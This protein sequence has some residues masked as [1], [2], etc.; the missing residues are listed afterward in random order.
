MGFFDI[1]TV[2]LIR[3]GAAFEELRLLSPYSK[4][5]LSR[6]ETDPGFCGL[7]DRP[8]HSN[9]TLL[10]TPTVL[11]VADDIGKQKSLSANIL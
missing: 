11:Q 9:R 2:L 10:V 3:C 8:S 4:D 5:I 7:M 6:I 1:H